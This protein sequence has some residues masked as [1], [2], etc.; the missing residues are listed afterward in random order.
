[1]NSFIKKLYSR[2]SV[3]AI[4]LLVSALSS[5]QNPSYGTLEWYLP[6]GEHQFNASI[7]TPE[8]VLGYQIGTYFINW[9]DVCKYM[10]RLDAVSDRVSL[11]R[12]G[13]TY[14]HREFIQIC[15]SSEENISNLEQIR[16]EHLQLCDPS[17][18]SVL[19]TDKMPVI[20][21]LMASVHG[22][23]TSGV[24]AA[25]LAAYFFAASDSPQI[26][27]MLESTIVIITPGLNP[28]GISRFAHWTNSTASK[29]KRADINGPRQM[30]PWPSSRTN[31]YYADCN[32]D[33]LSVQHPE[34]ANSVAM[35]KWWMPNIVLDMHEQ[36]TTSGFFFSLGDPNRTYSGISQ[37]NQDLTLKI[38]KNTAAEL[39]K[40]GIL[41]FSKE[42]YDDF[43]IGKGASYGDLQG[44]ICILHEQG[45]SYGYLRD[46]PWGILTFPETIR[47]QTL[48]AI[49]VATS[50]FRMREELLDYQKNY[51][52]DQLKIAQKDPMAGVRFAVKGDR[53]REYYLLKVLLTHDIP[54][55]RDSKEQGYIVPMVQDRYY[56][57]KAMWDN[58]TSFKDS[59]FYDVSTWSFPSAFGVESENLKSVQ[60]RLSERV[61]E[62]LFPKGFISGGISNIGYA[63]SNNEYYAPKMAS[64]LLKEG[65]LL[66]VS[67]KSFT[68][69]E[70]NLE[71]NFPAG[72]I[73]IPVYGQPA[74]GEM[75]Y[76]RISALAEQTGVQ[77]HSFKTSMMKDYDLGSTMYSSLKK[78]DVAIVTGRGLSSSNTG[79]AWFSIDRRFGFDHTMVDH[80]RITSSR[81]LSQYNVMVIFGGVPSP[82]QQDD[83]YET[84]GRWVK[85][86]G[87]LILGG[88]AAPIAQRAGLAEISTNSARGVS[89][90][91]LECNIDLES[92]LFWGFSESTLQVFKYRATVYSCEKGTAPM[93]YSQDP[94]ISGYITEENI[95]RFRGGQSIITYKA[96][97]G[98]VIFFADEVN[99]RSYW[100]STSKVFANAIL[101]GGLL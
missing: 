93:K 45:A 37:T 8:Q 69:V 34:G 85:G 65:F 55:Y 39:D 59:V 84:V 88:E 1:M 21:N 7:P 13:R 99:F 79:E 101:Y 67:G 68:S 18:S 58:I 11:K 60:G 95:D 52:T 48:A 36:G 42:S 82:L 56:T 30:E 3:L 77:V 29:N 27:E 80:S 81:D 78:P 28:D 9:S 31:H 51:F 86:G 40:K 26:K 2:V 63:F 76:E 97:R 53:T 17:R 23:E 10:E 75:L 94:Y 74:S 66:R 100:Y 98:R 61:T 15:V 44:S 70:G 96:G 62:A 12:F 87:I 35:Y 32:R 22:N 14:N 24:N 50:G 71:Y 57:F 6:D 19:E 89:G 43:Y 73:F 91:I 49:S 33:W 20:V 90:V 64:E 4:S 72:T 16:E 38:A 46:T 47:A 92:P 54:V 5:A 25:I 83:F 41:Y